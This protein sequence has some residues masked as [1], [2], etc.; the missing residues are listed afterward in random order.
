MKVFISNHLEKL[1]DLLQETI[2]QPHR[3]PLSKK[4]ILV[5]SEYFKQEIL[6]RWAYKTGIATG[7]TILTFQEA[8]NRVFPNIPCRSELMLKIE[9]SLDFIKETAIHSYLLSGS[10]EK[11]LAFCYQLSSVFLSYLYQD[12]FKFSEWLNRK[13]WQQDIWN[14]VFKN[15]NPWEKMI[16]LPGMVCIFHPY[17]M[18]QHE[19]KA[20]ENKNSYCFLFS[21]CSIFWGDFKSQYEQSVILSKASNLQ[22]RE[23]LNYFDQDHPLLSNWGKEGQKLLETFEEQES[24]DYYENNEKQIAVCQI[25]QEMLNLI[26][27]E[28]MRDHSIQ[29][30][31]APTRFREVEI[32]WEIIQRL[33]VEPREILVL[34][35][36]IE[37][38]ASIIEFIFQSRKG[39][40]D[41]T[42]LGLPSHLKSS[43]IQGF[44]DLI[45]LPRL[46]YSIE[47][48]EKILFCPSF[49]KR[50]QLNGED[51]K[52]LKKWIAVSNIHYDL[53]ADHTLCWKAGTQRLMEALITTS[54]TRQFSLN[55]S[56]A[57]LLNIWVSILKLLE[58][59]L[60]YIE[61]EKSLTLKEWSLFLQDFIK[62]FFYI[63][64][65]EEYVLFEIEKLKYWE[66]EGAFSFSIIEKILQAIFDRIVID[67]SVGNAQSVRF[68]PLH[69]GSITPAQVLIV[70]GM[71]EQTFP[72]NSYYSSLYEMNPPH[73]AEEDRYLFLEAFCHVRDTL[74][75][76]YSRF[77]DED[78]KLQKYSCL[79]QELI[80]YLPHLKIM[81]HP[82][83]AFDSWYFQETNFQS[84]SLVHWNVL[85]KK[86][87]M[88][89]LEKIKPILP[90][91]DFYKIDIRQL[92]LLARHPV[93]FFFQERFDMK[94]IQQDQETELLLSPLEMSRLRKRSLNQSI[95]ELLKDSEKEGVLPLGN[96]KKA[97]CLSIKKEIQ[98]YHQTLEKL[99]I[100]PSSI[101]S[102]ELRED[103][104][105]PQKVDDKFW[106][107]PALSVK[108]SLGKDICIVGK[109]EDICPQGLVFHGE[110]NISDL[111]KI[112]PQFLI[113]KNLQLPHD[114]NALFTK[115]G[116]I[117]P[118]QNKSPLMDLALYIEYTEKALR[119]P[120]PLIPSWAS[121][122]FKKNKIP[123][124]DEEDKITNWAHKRQLLPSYVDWYQEWIDDLK[125]I[126]HELL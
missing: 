111:L 64:S 70:M 54:E 5:P 93:R 51:A 87:N 97:A 18:T 116:A 8:M 21:P 43:F 60:D 79:I 37:E 94:F 44:K 59:K 23:L 120:S 83:S 82:I 114:C 38:Y 122:L 4:W 6:L 74:V 115:K 78:G 48:F 7:F 105:V 86:H 22:T 62:T 15:Q 69:K 124:I 126:F 47:S 24:F 68:V 2:N 118:L 32:V 76:T 27:I 98:T 1:I 88:R 75:L 33:S 67:R 92:K 121:T 109:I 57:D 39:R 65:S 101:Y 31:S 28:K 30:H 16:T 46:R 119:T 10:Q 77:N 123:E 61:K 42:V 34:V 91:L 112:W 25:Q 45:Q 63:E 90:P 36:N 9:Q 72:R 20:F 108:N 84:C 14:A 3:H 96:F 106:V 71:E 103:C 17:F 81:D 19:L 56:Q 102:I 35:P 73:Q 113:L 55:I 99:Q 100:D 89:S 29:I 117:N 110:G 95:D 66:L 26:S 11:R 13:G 52:Q 40:C 107:Y 49:L 41:Y 85:R 58:E 53:Q 104:L 125:R 50:F 80:D 12:P